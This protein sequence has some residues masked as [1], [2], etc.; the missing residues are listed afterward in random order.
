MKVFF[1]LTLILLLSLCSASVIFF[2]S[3]GFIVSYHAGNPEKS[4]VIIVLGGDNGL[5]VHK[6]A[7]LYNAGYASHVIV[8]GIDERFYHPSHPNWR[9]RRM[10]ALGVPKKAITVDALSTTT[11]EEAENT[12][13]TMEEQGWK[14][15]IV[16][17]DPP[18]M[19]RL[20]QTWSKALDGT[21]LKFILVPTK[22]L[23]WNPLFWWNN[24]KSFQFVMNEIKKNL[25]YAIVY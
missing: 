20:Y 5:R 2:L 14:S 3:L 1:K 13:D 9:V 11:W 25:F 24:E 19:L 8:T 6:G 21:S 23:W 16:V 7:E 22:P 12:A 10:V 4:D 17:S 15:A 18:H